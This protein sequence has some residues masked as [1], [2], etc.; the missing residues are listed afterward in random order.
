MFPQTNLSHVLLG[1]NYN[2]F[3][4]TV[5]LH[6]QAKL[7]LFQWCFVRHFG[8][9]T[10]L[11]KVTRALGTEATSGNLETN[12]SYFHFRSN[13]SCSDF[14]Q[15]KCDP[16][17]FIPESLVPDRWSRVTRTLGTRL[18]KTFCVWQI[19]IDIHEI[20]IRVRNGKQLKKKKK[21]Q[22]CF[23]FCLQTLCGF[24]AFAVYFSVLAE[25]CWLLLHGLRIHGKIK[26]IFA[27]NLN[28]EI[29]YVVI[30]WGKTR[31][32]LLLWFVILFCRFVFLF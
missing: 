18:R 15:W 2:I 28:I 23:L 13:C 3:K 14:S 5:V 26:K 25:F 8:L 30:G 16:K 6:L 27:S 11:E 24:L 12:Y 22:N 10:P 31:S 4:R 21:M 9:K 32:I 20:E 17:R 19:I 7:S 29:V 1:R